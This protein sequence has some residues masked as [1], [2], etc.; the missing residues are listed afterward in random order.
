[1]K[2]DLRRTPAWAPAA[3]G[4]V[5]VN[6]ASRPPQFLGCA[7]SD[8]EGMI[9]N[10]VLDDLQLRDEQKLTVDIGMPKT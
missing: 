6:L 1:M 8:P 3:G 10:I 5:V 2:F 7:S 9:F 4:V